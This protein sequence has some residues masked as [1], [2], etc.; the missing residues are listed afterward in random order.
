MAGIAQRPVGPT[1]ERQRL[2]G[3]SWEMEVVGSTVDT[4]PKP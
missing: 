2:T 1:T 3:E 4:L